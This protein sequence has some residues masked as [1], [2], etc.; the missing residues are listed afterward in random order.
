MSSLAATTRINE[1]GLPLGAQVNPR[2]EI[3]AQLPGRYQH[4]NR[5]LD[6]DQSV[7]SEN[8]RYIRSPSSA[9]ELQ[10][11]HNNGTTTFSVH[12]PPEAAFCREKQVSI[13]QVTDPTN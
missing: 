3:D 4:W 1:T 12:W 8:D 11:I 2:S 10:D 9:L 7:Y 5:S 13:Q 6:L